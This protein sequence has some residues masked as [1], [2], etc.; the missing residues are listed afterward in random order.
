MSRSN[1]KDFEVVYK[2]KHRRPIYQIGLRYKTYPDN[3][4][5][6][7]IEEDVNDL[8]ADDSQEKKS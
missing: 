3:G 4:D 7:S 8:K 5:V 2:R 1:K 6:K